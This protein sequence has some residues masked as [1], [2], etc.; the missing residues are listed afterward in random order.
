MKTIITFAVILG[1]LCGGIY[2]YEQIKKSDITNPVS[3]QNIASLQN[4][5]TINHPSWSDTLVPVQN[6]PGRV[7]RKD[8]GDF[9]TIVEL[10]PNSITISWDNWGI[11]TF[12]KNENNIYVFKE[13]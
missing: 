6:E 7:K 11:E 10:K 12:E 5:I 1:I 4:E 8:G 13:N 3:L 2:Y 9:A